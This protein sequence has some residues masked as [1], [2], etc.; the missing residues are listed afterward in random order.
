MNAGTH[1]ATAPALVALGLDRWRVL[2]A[3]GGV[4]G[5]IDALARPDGMRYRARRYRWSSRAFID[6]GEFWRR[7]DA[8]A[9]LRRG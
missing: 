9:V 3:A 6:V 2:D 1:T 7:D 4:I 5:V 8:V